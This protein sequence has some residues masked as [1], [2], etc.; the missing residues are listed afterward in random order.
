MVDAACGSAVRSQACVPWDVNEEPDSLVLTS[1]P[2]LLTSLLLLLTSLALLLASLPL[3]LT[4]LELCLRSVD[5][6]STAELLPKR[7]VFSPLLLLCSRLHA[8]LV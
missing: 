5:P 6:E 3:L 1:L 7:A 4:S 2:L 8:P